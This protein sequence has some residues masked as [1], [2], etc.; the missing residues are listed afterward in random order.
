MRG[1]SGRDTDR[2]VEPRGHVCHPAG[3]S[4]VRQPSGS[5]TGAQGEPSVASPIQG[6]LARLHAEY[7]G[8]NEGQVAR[9]IP[10]LADTDPALFGICLATADG[11]VY[12]VGDTGHPFTIQSISK[13]LT[14]GMILD[15][16]GDAAVRSRIG[17][18]PTGDAFNAITLDPHRGTPANPMINAGA[19]TATAMLGGSDPLA[20]LLGE[21]S[22]YTDRELSLNEAVYA[23]ECATGHRNRAIAHLL[24]G[25]GAIETDPEAALDLYFQQCSTE[26]T[27]RDLALMAA[28]LA[29]GG[30]NPVT[31]VRAASVATT[32]AM[33]TVMATCGMY[34]GAGDWLYTV[35]LPAKS[36]VSGGI[37]AVLPGRL[38][39]AVFSPLLDAH[40]N[41]VRGVRVCRDLARD[42]GLR[43]IEFGDAPP[44]R[45][46]HSIAERGSKRIRSALERAVLT[47]RGDEVTALELQGDLEFPEVERVIRHLVGSPAGVNLA[48]LDFSRVTQIAPVAAPFFADLHHEYSARGGRLLLSGLARHGGFLDTMR[49]L[50]AGASADEIGPLSF[51]EL[52]A[53]LEWCETH[54]LIASEVAANTA[55]VDLADHDLLAGLSDP[56]LLAVRRLLECH[57]FAAGERVLGPGADAEEL[58]LIT[59]GKLSVM[60]TGAGGQPRRLATLSAG[61]VLGELAFATGEARTS[62]VWAD[63]AVECYSLSAADLAS[64]ACERPAAEAAILRNLVGITSTRASQM[65][66][67]LALVTD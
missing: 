65:R 14:F 46:A 34:D 59:R 15:E 32:R 67:E 56:D 11:A 10:E 25:S 13:P 51:S 45:A 38:G 12:E 2:A 62:T 48:V 64:L 54:L 37:L 58:Y 49:R 42:L 27:C 4:T 47:E 31:G 52:D 44:I 19:I 21:Y 55:S 22:R 30:T 6:Y 16:F 66:G 8:L 20:Q 1:T 50:T 9:Y 33:L 41:S 3:M 61:M 7:A 63:S 53:A 40:G 60:T 17:V 36:G 5:G 39:I 23:S 28:T 43:L 35:G 29:N 26:V 24:Y 57:E 18:E